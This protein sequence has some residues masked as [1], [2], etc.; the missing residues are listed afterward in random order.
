ML[1]QIVG[2]VRNDP[3]R[4]REP[5]HH[6]NTSLICESTAMGRPSSSGN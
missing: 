4:E 3:R 6:V 1:R 2:D 5:Q